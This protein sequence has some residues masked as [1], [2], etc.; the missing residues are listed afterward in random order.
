MLFVYASVQQS[1]RE[2][3]NDPQIQMAED[4]AN[5]LKNGQ[6]PAGVVGRGNIIDISESLSPFLIIY[7][8][9]GLPLESPAKLDDTVPVPPKGVFQYALK[10]G[11]DSVTWHPERDV[12]I[13]SVIQSYRSE[14]TSGFV[15]AGRSLR[16]V[17]KR[18]E[19]LSRFTM[20]T[21]FGVVFMSIISTC[22]L[23][24]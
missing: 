5:D 4:A 6:A 13:A 10:H 14:S 12:R 16:E 2:S 3:A 21:L 24:L 23:F 8:S 17:E 9:T 20:L 18:E 11:Q 7:D 15:L 19:N 1:L 22:I